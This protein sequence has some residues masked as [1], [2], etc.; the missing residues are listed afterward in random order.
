MRIRGLAAH[1]TLRS[2][3]SAVTASV[4]T[5]TDYGSFGACICK[6]LRDRGFEHKEVREDKSVKDKEVLGT[7]KNKVSGPRATGAFGNE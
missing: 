1:H 5:T 2:I 4:L 6:A 3:S 7:Q